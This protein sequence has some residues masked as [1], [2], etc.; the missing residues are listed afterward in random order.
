MFFKPCVL[1]PKN[2]R[3]LA[4]LKVKLSYKWP[5]HS[6]SLIKKDMLM[7]CPLDQAESGWADVIARPYMVPTHFK[8]EPSML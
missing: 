4:D 7:T 1:S 5:R 3:A 6:L 8:H 2:C